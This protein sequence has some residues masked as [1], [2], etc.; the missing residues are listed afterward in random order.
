MNSGI[1]GKFKKIFEKKNT[2]NLGVENNNKIN[3]NDSTDINQRCMTSNYINDNPLS[4]KGHKH[5]ASNQ[6]LTSSKST[7]SIKEK[8]QITETQKSDNIKLKRKS[9][10]K[11]TNSFTSKDIKKNKNDLKKPKINNSD[12]KSETKQ[13]NSL[14]NHYQSI[15]NEKTFDRIHNLQILIKKESALK[16]LCKLI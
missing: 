14:F 9:S 8:I 10:P 3:D 2:F 6:I 4:E 11:I 1:L 16:E 12:N 5:S 13:I 7:Y 15:K